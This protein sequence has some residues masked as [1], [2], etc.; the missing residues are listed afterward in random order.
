MAS[1]SS[2]A[3]GLLAV[4][5]ALAAVAALLAVATQVTTTARDFRCFYS[6][7]YLV[8]RYPP[9]RLY[10]PGLHRQ[11][12]QQLFGATDPLTYNHT[13]PEALLLAALAALPY[14]Q[15]AWVW[16]LGSLLALGLGFW[17]LRA[18]SR[19]TSLSSRLSLVLLTGLAVGSFGALGQDTAFLLPIFAGGLLLAQRGREMAAGAVLGLGLYRFEMLL[20]FL[21][22]FALRRRWRLLAGAA[23][24]A[25]AGLAVS[26]VMVGTAGLR[27]Y[28]NLLL[29]TGSVYGEGLD[30]MPQAM[31]NLRG[32]IVTLLGSRLAART[33]VALIALA[34]LVTL[35]W[36]ARRFT[37]ARDPTGPGYATQYAAAVVLAL[38][39]SYHLYVYTLTPLLLVAY[40]DLSRP[41]TWWRKPSLLFLPVMAAA[42]VALYF[43]PFP[44]ALLGPLLWVA[45]GALFAAAPLGPHSPS[46]PAVGSG[47]R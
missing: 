3:A 17:W 33:L 31:P 21:A 39:A 12:Q 23:L 38:V 47:N 22:I 7:G 16:L 25:A 43:G 13:P 32:L 41:G 29:A 24:V 35:V 28:G 34:S 8:R 6:T 1:R 2:H 40:V 5:L 46:A 4:V 42:V 20:P 27:S 26:W 15:A 10:D 37:A 14:R 9:S 36:A 44:Y 11:I 18:I 45:A 19:L 30:V